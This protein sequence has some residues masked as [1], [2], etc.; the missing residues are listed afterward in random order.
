MALPRGHDTSMDQEKLNYGRKCVTWLADNRISFDEF[1]YNMTITIISLSDDGMRSGIE[2]IPVCAIEQYAEYLRGFLEAVD[3]K[4]DPMPFL[5][6]PV[7]EQEVEKAKEEMRPRYLL[8]H[9]LLKQKAPE[10]VAEP[11]SLSGC[12]YRAER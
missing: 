12:T 2:L 9:Q 10:V 5:V 8:L 4:P 6:G 7:S 3:Y 11:E 1:A